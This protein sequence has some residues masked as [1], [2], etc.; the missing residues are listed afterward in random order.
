MKEKDLKT[1]KKEINREDVEERNRKD[2]ATDKKKKR[3]IGKII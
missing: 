2:R 1:G 3:G